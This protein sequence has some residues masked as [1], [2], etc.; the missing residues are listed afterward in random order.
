MALAGLEGGH[1]IAEELL[2]TIRILQ[3]HQG[4]YVPDMQMADYVFDGPALELGD[5]G[6]QVITGIA[7][8][9]RE[10]IAFVFEIPGFLHHHIIP[11]WSSS[12][13]ASAAGMA[14]GWASNIWP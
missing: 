12:L 13:S 4:G 6:Q 14:T 7:E 3:G 11:C 5:R 8:H 9:G 2:E 10:R 1:D